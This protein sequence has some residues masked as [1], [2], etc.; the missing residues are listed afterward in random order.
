MVS[1]ALCHESYS[2]LVLYQVLLFSSDMNV[3]VVP[4]DSCDT[5]ELS[6]ILIDVVVI[7]VLTGFSGS[8]VLSRETLH[9]SV[10]FHM[11][12]LPE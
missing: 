5:L 11:Q 8:L 3:G 4:L 1:I 6:S 10:F 2:S 7:V 12:L 9:G